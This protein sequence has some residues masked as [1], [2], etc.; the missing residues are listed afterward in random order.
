M[1]WRVRG[2]AES[3]GETRPTVI[4][5]TSLTDTADDRCRQ[6]VRSNDGTE[7]VQAR[8][9]IYR[10]DRPDVR[11]IVAGMAGTVAGEERRA[12]RHLHRAGRHGIRAARLLRRTDQDAEPG[13]ARG[14]RA[15][16]QQHAHDRA[17]LADPV[18]HP[19]RPQSP[20]E[21]HVVYYRRIDGLPGRQRQHP[22]RERFSLRDPR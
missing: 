14:Q 11:Q 3:R 7:G 8:N 20:L 5:A 12:Q 9:R 10:R 16:V 15:A 1:W 13:L 4:K 2:L 22:V 6:K 18:V 19:D 17:V 21:R